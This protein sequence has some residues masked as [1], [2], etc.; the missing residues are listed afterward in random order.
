MLLFCNTDEEGNVTDALQGERVVPAKQYDHFFYM[1][2]DIE[3]VS[4]YRVQTD[5]D[6][7]AQLVSKEPPAEEETSTDTVPVDDETKEAE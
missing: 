5:S 1:Q 6:G 4:Q 3:D 2:E 7:T